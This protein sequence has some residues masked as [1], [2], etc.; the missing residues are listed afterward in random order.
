MRYTAPD[1][2]SCQDELWFNGGRFAAPLRTGLPQPVMPAGSVVPVPMP[3]HA[4]TFPLGFSWLSP[5]H[6]PSNE[7][8]ETYAAMI[9]AQEGIPVQF[10]D[11][12]RREAELQL[13]V[14]RTEIHLP[15]NPPRRRK[16]RVCLTTVAA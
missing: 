3:S 1:R 10:A 12:F 11:E 4:F 5:A 15:P 8:I 9:A 13:W 7:E 14:W 6:H 2:I 16:N